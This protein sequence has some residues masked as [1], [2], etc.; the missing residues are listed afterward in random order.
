LLTN[1]LGIITLVVRVIQGNPRPS[2]LLVLNTITSLEELEPTLARRES[3]VP[4]ITECP[5][6][7]AHALNHKQVLLVLA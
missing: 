6:E 1:G 7:H 2:L 4:G 3:V 5:A